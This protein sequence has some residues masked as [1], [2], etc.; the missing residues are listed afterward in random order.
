[1]TAPFSAAERRALEAE[2]AR[3]VEQ[4]QCP[5]CD[6][7]L[8]QQRVDPGAAVAYVRRRVLVICPACR[9]TAALDQ[10]KES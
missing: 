8:S 6:T 7:P 4:L 1:L 3:G 5:A 10:K 9:R 2:L